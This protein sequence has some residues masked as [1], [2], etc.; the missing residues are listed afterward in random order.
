MKR[1]S[2]LPEL[3]FL[4]TI[5][6]VGIAASITFMPANFGPYATAAFVFVCTLGAAALALFNLD[7]ITR[8]SGHGPDDEEV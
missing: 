6:A 8:L 2:S 4:M 3:A 5:C 1:P 7:L